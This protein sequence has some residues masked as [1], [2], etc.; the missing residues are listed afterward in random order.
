MKRLLKV[1]IFG[2]YE[3]MEILP[4]LTK[5]MNILLSINTG[6]VYMNLLSLCVSDWLTEFVILCF[7]VDIYVSYPIR[8][9]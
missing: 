9:I 5:V 7:M 1:Y 4:P 3:M 6:A 8:V 2:P